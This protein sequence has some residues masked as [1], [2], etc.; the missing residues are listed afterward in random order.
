M[1]ECAVD[2]CERPVRSRGMCSAHYQ[3]WMRKGDTRSTVIRDDPATRFWSK[4]TRSA[5]GCRLWTGYITPLGYGRFK[6]NGEMRPT[7]QVAFELV[8]GP[9]EDGYE[10]DHRC[11]Q[12]ACVEPSHLEAVTHRENTHRGSGWAGRH[13]RATECAKGHRFSPENTRLDSRGWR[14]CRECERE[15]GQRRRQEATLTG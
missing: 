6:I 10:P 13:A 9:V 1:A 14:V 8:N 12:R 4:T 3:R 7:H 2:R 5:E 11:R 15:R